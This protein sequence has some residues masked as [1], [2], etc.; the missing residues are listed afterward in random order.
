MGHLPSLEKK[1][2]I[3]FNNQL[4]FLSFDYFHILFIY[5][6]F[7]YGYIYLVCKLWLIIT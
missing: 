6:C 7:I 4:L 2:K 3:F 1:Y 5:L